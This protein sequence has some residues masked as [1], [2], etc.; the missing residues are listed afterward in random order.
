LGFYEGGK[1]EELTIALMKECILEKDEEY[2]DE[3]I[4]E[5]LDDWKM[6]NKVMDIILKDLPKQPLEEEIDKFRR[7]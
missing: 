2:I 4:E 5:I 3:V 1:E 7:G 6:F